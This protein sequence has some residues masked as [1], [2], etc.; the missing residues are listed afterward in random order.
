[1]DGSGG[2]QFFLAVFDPLF[3]GFAELVMAQAVAGKGR[4]HNHQVGRFGREHLL[5]GVHLGDGVLGAGP[6][7]QVGLAVQKLQRSEKRFALSVNAEQ[8]TPDFHVAE[9]GSRREQAERGCGHV[10]GGQVDVVAA[11]HLLDERPCRAVGIAGLL[12]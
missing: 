6:G 9:L 1:M 7:Q 11:Q 3:V 2:K 8:G 12:C 4:I 10:G 5:A